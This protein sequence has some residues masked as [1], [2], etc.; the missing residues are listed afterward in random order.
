MSNTTDD[1]R[2]GETTKTKRVSRLDHSKSAM[3]H[4]FVRR[5][6]EN[7]G[8]HAIDEFIQWHCSEPRLSLSRW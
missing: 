8:T 2:Q 1:I 6:L 7:Q 3:C 4:S 5:S